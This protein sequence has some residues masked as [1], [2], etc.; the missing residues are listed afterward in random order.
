MLERSFNPGACDQLKDCPKLEA[1][2]VAGQ[3][4]TPRLAAHGD[5]LPLKVKSFSPSLRAVLVYLVE[6]CPVI[7]LGDADTGVTA[8][9]LYREP[10]PHGLQ[11]TPNCADF[12]AF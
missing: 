2:S 12:G 1:T 8:N 10:S 4:C 7:F 9:E 11:V 6:A 3:E 5:Y